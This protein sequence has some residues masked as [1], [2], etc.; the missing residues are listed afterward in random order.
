MTKKLTPEQ[1][2]ENARVSK[3]YRLLGAFIRFNKTYIDFVWSGAQDFCLDD[4]YLCLY[5]PVHSLYAFPP[6]GELRDP[7]TEDQISDFFALLEDAV[8]EGAAIYRR[9]KFGFVWLVFDFEA[10]QSV[11]L[12]HGINPD[13]YLDAR[14]KNPSEIK[15]EMMSKS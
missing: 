13:D 3:M 9:D 4:I 10:Y 6:R 7:L 14:K 8:R 2:G 12:R 5:C 15:A 1:K 11:C